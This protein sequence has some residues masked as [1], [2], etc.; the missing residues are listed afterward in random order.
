MMTDFYQV[1]GNDADV[2]C[3][4]P[5]EI[6]AELNKEL[7]ENLMYIQDDSGRCNVIVRPEHFFENIKMITQ[8]DLDPEKDADLIAKLKI[9]PQDKWGQYFY[10]IQK[11][12]PL[13][14]TKVG[15]DHRLISIE[16]MVGNPLSEKKAEIIESAIRPSE[17]PNPFVMLFECENGES[18]PISFQQQPF[19]SLTEIMFSNIDFQALNIAIYIY[20]PLT[21][22]DEKGARTS[23]RHPESVTYSV[24]PTMA[25]SVSDAVKALHIFG[26]LFSGTTK[27]NGQ[28]LVSEDAQ[29][30]FDQEKIEDAIAFWT[31]ARKLEEI[32]K[33]RFSPG[34]EFPMD[35]ARFFAEMD[36]CLIQNKQIVWNHPFDSFHVN[37][38][39]IIDDSRIENGIFD[40]GNL[41]IQFMEGPILATL[42]GAKFEIYSQTTMND[43]VV[44]NIQWD[45]ETQQSGEVYISDVPG[46]IWTLKRLYMTKEM[47]DS[48][49]KRNG[50]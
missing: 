49:Y 14:N 32:L 48:I 18:V 38:L 12:I 39:K 44:T 1:F 34:A 7:P 3:R 40:S 19:D 13:K 31:T 9:I 2:D 20:C 11:S 27:V 23:K 30:N 35:D 28:V 29:K 47:A 43:I 4:V 24:T 17:F 25:D 21:D 8:F 5:Q 6:L 22:K 15:S 33:I 37:G 36:A 41:S 46:K 42:L 26:G 10:R 16:R 45:D 50:N